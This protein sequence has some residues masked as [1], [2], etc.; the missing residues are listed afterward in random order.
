MFNNYKH[1]HFIGI[2]GSGISA[3]A[4]LVLSGGVRVSGSDSNRSIFVEDLIKDGAEI[5]IGHRNNID[6]DIDLVIY[7]EAIDKNIN[8][9]YLDAIN[10]NIKTMSYFEAIGEISKHKKTIAIAGTHGKT[11]T[12]AMLGVALMRNSQFPCLP[13]RQAISNFQLDTNRKPEENKRKIPTA[14]A[15]Q[16]K[17]MDNKVDPRVKPE[18]DSCDATVILGSRVKEFGDR[19]IY[20]P[21]N[22][23]EGDSGEEWFVVEACEYRRSF[24]NIEPFGV[25]L[26]NCELDHLD[27]YKN[28]EDYLSAFID[29]VNKIP[30]DGFLVANM[31]DKNVVKATSY[32]KGRVIEVNSDII[33]KLNLELSVFGEYNKS[34]AVHAYFAGLEIGNNNEEIRKGL[35][36]FKGVGRRMEL[37]GE[38]NDAKI[39]NDY[40]HHPTEIV[41]S[42]KSLKNEFSDKKI[43]CVFQPH[44]YSRTYEFLNGFKDSFE[45]A[46]MV[47]VPNIFEA[48]D[49]DEDKKKINAESFVEHLSKNHSNVIW[50]DGFDNTLKRLKG[51]VNEGD[52]VVF[53]GAG[54]V[55][56]ISDGLLG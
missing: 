27:Y 4:S 46:D 5:V 52:V 31:D 15:N 8:K 51:S 36:K 47:I 17:N 1:I 39:F 53:M 2:G 25:V 12:T 32:C 49:S 19:N 16:Q 30:S 26:L 24:L 7:T 11:S 42:L 44:Q 28:E 38:F 21:T 43:I 9:E 37:R 56:M 10:R 41:A 54:D 3:V 18:D 55:N 34:N 33:N 23:G 40:A 6:S 45:D 48:R 50:G 13:D 22:K 14:S 20:I 29:L 35:L